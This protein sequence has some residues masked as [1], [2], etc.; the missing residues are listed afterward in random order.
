MANRVLLPPKRVGESVL[1]PQFDF[2]S[3]FASSTDSILSFSAVA[4]VYSGVDPSPSL[5]ITSASFSG[6]VVSVLTSGSGV[7]GV[8]YELRV[9]ALLA[10]GQGPVLCGYLAIIPDL[11]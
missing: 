4:S 11:P 6:S 7:L 10:S 8:I 5:I 1:Y 9:Q 3:A 2:L